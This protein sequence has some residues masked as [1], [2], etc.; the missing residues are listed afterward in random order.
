M[1]LLKREVV[2]LDA[3]RSH[4]WTDDV[5]HLAFSAVLLAFFGV[6]SL[7]NTSD[8]FRVGSSDSAPPDVRRLL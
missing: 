4:F 2:D 5:L 1:N 7:A 3:D 6:V 8:V